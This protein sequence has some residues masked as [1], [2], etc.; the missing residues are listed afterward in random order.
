MLPVQKHSLSLMCGEAPLIS[1]MYHGGTIWKTLHPWDSSCPTTANI[2]AIITKIK[3]P[4]S[5]RQPLH[6]IVE[7]QLLQPLTVV[8]ESA[9]KAPPH[10]HITPHSNHTYIFFTKIYLGKLSLQ[11]HPSCTSSTPHHSTKL[12]SAACLHL[13][14]YTLSC[15]TTNHLS[16]PGK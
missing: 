3:I 13:F 1:H 10:L 6:L 14:S 16:M 11:I 8:I 9:T 15:E 4:E 12:V 2:A 5:W 7:L